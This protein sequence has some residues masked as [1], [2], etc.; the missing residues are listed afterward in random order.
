MQKST[1][2]IWLACWALAVASGIVFRPVLPVDETRYLSVAWEMWFRGDFIVPYLNGEPYHH[3]PPLLFWLMT[4]GW[5]VFGVNEWWPRLVAPLFAVGTLWGSV[6]LASLLWP[7][8][9][10]TPQLTPLF[11]VG[12]AFWAIF[13]TVTM[14]DMMLATFT[15][16]G[17]LGV[18]T[19]WRT[20]SWSSW[21]LVGLAIGLGVLAKGPAILLHILPVV[22]L[23][24]WWGPKLPNAP[25]QPLIRWGQWYF[26][27]FISVLIG[28]AIALAWAIPAGIQGG[29]EY[30]NMI[31]WGQ[32]AGR[33]VKS[34]DHARPFWWYLAVI[35]PLL[36]PWLLWPQLWRNLRSKIGV[37]DGAFRLL[38]AWVGPAVFVFSLI[39][40]KQ[41]HYLLPE[42]AA[43]AMM[44]ARVLS[45]QVDK[46]V[47]RSNRALVS[48]FFAV[49][50]ILLLV[51]P[52]LSGLMS[53]PQR[54]ELLDP[55][56]GGAL[57]M[58]VALIWFLGARSVGA[59]V[60]VIAV[61]MSGLIL[62][63]HLVAKDKLDQTYDLTPIA[64]ALKKYED[65]G[66]ALANF[67]T[68]HGQ[69]QFLGRLRTPL[70]QLGIDYDE[71]SAYI[72][73]TNKG[74]VVA[75]YYRRNMPVFPADAVPLEEFRFRDFNVKIWSIDLF[76][77]YRKL[78]N[79]T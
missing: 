57:A 49:L 34:F 38:A 23:A 61:C 2:P 63:A 26:R 5:S 54:F 20:G 60:K 64:M 33:I 66:Y 44:F 12:T 79:R 43:F 40:G 29:E 1:L 53:N 65:K 21:L 27:L 69:F 25:D 36:L 32:S 74:V 8:D 47:S 59:V 41:L 9:K 55:Y 11:Q 24:P 51:F 72:D 77:K 46:P 16:M 67:G 39:S 28:A 76:K 4:A 70:A 30:R 75:Y 71:T 35:P 52:H 7:D 22:L 73:S 62:V 56:W 58:M 48:A 31:F 13:Q 45:D 10:I 50:C 68:Y 37:S 6:R 19:S 17:L 3:K 14:F 18:V 42:F 15:V 78:G